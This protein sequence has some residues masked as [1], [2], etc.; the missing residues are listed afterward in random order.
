M[1][2]V[3]L[4][5]LSSVLD[6]RRIRREIDTDSIHTCM[7][8]RRCK[9]IWTLLTTSRGDALHDSDVEVKTKNAEE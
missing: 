7:H 8:V 5:S 2:G 4:R 6:G 3:F 1:C 9:S